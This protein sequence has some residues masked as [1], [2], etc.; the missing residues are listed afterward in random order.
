MLKFFKNLIKNKPSTAQTGNE[1][2]NIQRPVVKAEGAQSVFVLVEWPVTF[3]KL[4]HPKSDKVHPKSDKPVSIVER[5]VMEGG[6]DIEDVEWGIKVNQ[7]RA[8]STEKQELAKNRH[9]SVAGEGDELFIVEVQVD[10]AVKTKIQ[11]IKPKD[12][13]GFLSSLIGVSITEEEIVNPHYDANIESK[14]IVSATRVYIKSEE[15]KNP[16]YDASKVYDGRSTEVSQENSAG[17]TSSSF[18]NN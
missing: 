6:F 13:F 15:I 3:K 4:V 1:L 14:Y 2:E 16:H 9:R 12:R 17:S 5:S 18:L 11:N 10:E 7:I 8:I